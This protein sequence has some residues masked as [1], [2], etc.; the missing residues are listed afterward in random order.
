MPSKYLNHEKH[1]EKKQVGSDFQISLSQRIS[2]QLSPLIQQIVADEISLMRS[3]AAR[4]LEG[5]FEDLGLLLSTERKEQSLTLDQLADLSG[6]SK[7]TIQRMESAK[8]IEALATNL[9]NIAIIS[10]TL[11]V[12]LSLR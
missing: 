5:T 4:T 7:A 10:R 2:K 3:K 1:L 12:S 11:G 6:V 9:Q 8:S